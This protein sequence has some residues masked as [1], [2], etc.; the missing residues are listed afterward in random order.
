M[1]RYRFDISYDGT[2]YV[3]WQIQPNGLAIQEVIQDAMER[4]LCKRIKLHGSG[5]TDQGV[6]AR[7]Q[8]AHADI[9]SSWLPGKLTTALNAVLPPD[10]RIMRATKVPQTFHARHSV[11]LKE[12]R[13]FI[14]NSDVMPPTKRHYAT[15]MRQPLDAVAMQ[16]AADY[17][18]GTHDFSAFSAN[19]KRHVESHVRRL[20]RLDIRKRGA[21]ITIIAAGEGFL[22]KMVRSLAGFLMRVGEG[23]VPPATAKEILASAVRTARVPTAPP[24]GLFLWNVTY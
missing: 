23:T 12:Y 13:Y 17:L 3:G 5:R 21:E 19:P 8:V 16:K 15:H 1:Q 7:K 24:E 20:E 10:I 18:V 14:W 11:R 9:S 22:Y 4:I 6:H 2:A